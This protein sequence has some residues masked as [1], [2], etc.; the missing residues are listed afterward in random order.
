MHGSMEMT[1][2]LVTTALYMATLDQV[3]ACSGVAL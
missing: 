2:S 1:V 3:V